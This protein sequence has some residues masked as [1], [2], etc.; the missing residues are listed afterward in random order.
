[1]EAFLHLQQVLQLLTNKFQINNPNNQTR[2]N[3]SKLK[4]K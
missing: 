1:M 4:N 3:N 2:V